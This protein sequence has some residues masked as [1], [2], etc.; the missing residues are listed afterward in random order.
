[1]SDASS[2]QRAAIDQILRPDRPPTPGV[3]RCDAESPIVAVAKG[4]LA[5]QFALTGMR[6]EEVND[7]L[8]AE[9]VV[10]ALLRSAAE[11]VIIDDRLREGCSP[12]LTE[13]LDE[14]KGLPLV[15]YCPSFEHDVAGAEAAIA[16]ELKRVIGYEIR[17]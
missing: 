2:P 8:E 12:E 15:V 17:I 5:L 3:E 11:M 10:A 1:M 16:S 7:A 14:H 13:K 6:V 9:T 4:H